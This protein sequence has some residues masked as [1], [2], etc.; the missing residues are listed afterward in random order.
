METDLAKKT[1]CIL[2]SWDFDMH[3]LGSGKLDFGTK[4]FKQNISNF[5][6]TMLNK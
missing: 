2:I 1:H 3:E 5:A 4:F 6:F